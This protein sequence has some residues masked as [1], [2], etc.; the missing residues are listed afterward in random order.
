MSDQSL[1][2]DAAHDELASALL[3]GEIDRPSE[4]DAT[5]DARVR[6]LRTVAD[7]IAAPVPIDEL[8]RERA[9][10]AAL[11]AFDAAAP[12]APAQA[13]PR[14]RGFIP[15]LVGAAAVVIV[16]IGAVA[17]L[18]HDS[19]K[20][21]DTAS[22]VVDESAGLTTTLAGGEAPA[23]AASDRGVANAGGAATAA[24]PLQAPAPAVAALGDIADQDSL[25]AAIGGL[26]FAA[27]A[28][29]PVTDACEAPA[30]QGAADLGTLTA[31]VPL[32][33]QGQAARALVFVGTSPDAAPHI[34]VVADPTCEVLDRID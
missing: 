21:T 27:K 8:A 17:V 11:G 14:R 28:A 13:A 6:E 9:I 31:S 29:P 12:A 23:G 3:D 1:S 26:S 19:S 24:A 25:R 30:R 22:G 16:A 32:H 34:V 20:S 2:G 4:L 7:A 15:A 10:A 18:Q 5:V 33:W